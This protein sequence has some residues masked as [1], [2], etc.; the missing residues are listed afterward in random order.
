M[1]VEG[2][3]RPDRGHA[4]RVI[5]QYVLEPHQEVENDDAHQVEHQHGEGIG[6]PVLVFALAGAGDG[7][8]PSFDRNEDR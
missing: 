4:G 7:V 3:F 5:G 8:K 2:E 6:G 1:A